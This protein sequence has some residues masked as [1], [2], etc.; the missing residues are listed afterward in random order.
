MREHIG[1]EI[2]FMVDANYGMEAEKAIRAAQA[3]A[4]YNLVW[5]EE[6]ID[7]N[8][9]DGYKRISQE[10]GHP[11]AAGEN[12]HSILDFRLLCANNSLSFLQPDA[13]TCGGITKW[14]RAAEMGE[15]HGLSVCSHGMQEMHVSLLAG[16]ENSGWLEVHG[17]P[18]DEYT[19]R[20]LV[21]EEQLAV[22]PEAPGTG[23]EFEWDKL[24]PFLVQ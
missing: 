22:A 21:V 3:F 16:R 24:S 23:V 6:P 18:I 9:F 10:T 5:F 8:D 7:P 11:L 19:T 13:G 14:L 4:P 15:S 17:F 20:P 1:P 12:S 2:A